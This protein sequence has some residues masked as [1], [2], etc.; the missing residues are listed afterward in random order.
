MIEWSQATDTEFEELSPGNRTPQD[1][2]WD[3]IITTLAS[4][5]PVRLPFQTE[6]EKRSLRL[7]LGKRAAKRGLKLE[8]RSG[9]GY[10]IAR[11]EKASRKPKRTA[12]EVTAEATASFSPARQDR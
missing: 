2:A 9:D 10:L 5:T 11:R 4:G 1:R 3:Q 12:E 8:V 6:S 7:A